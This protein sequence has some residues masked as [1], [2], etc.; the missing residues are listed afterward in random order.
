MVIR[1]TVNASAPISPTNTQETLN[2]FYALVIADHSH[3]RPS[4][5]AIFQMFCIQN[6]DQ[7]NA[8][9]TCYILHSCNVN[10][11]DCQLCF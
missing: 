1:F 6:V 11:T 3:M 7:V 4:A 8:S 5:L 9:V 2:A 10:T